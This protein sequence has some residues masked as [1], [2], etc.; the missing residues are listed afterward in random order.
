[1]SLRCL[2]GVVLTVNLR[3][4]DPMMTT[5]DAMIERR[6][7]GFAQNNSRNGATDV[8]KPAVAIEEGRGCY[9][10]QALKGT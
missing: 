3:A 7:A 8:N 10:F 2:E 1:M 9:Q 4:L 5:W 6:S